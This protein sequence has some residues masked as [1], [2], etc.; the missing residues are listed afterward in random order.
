MLRSP[1]GVRC[2]YVQ[3]VC[4]VITIRARLSKELCPGVSETLC[5]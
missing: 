5:I 3:I 1:N 2:G 4:K